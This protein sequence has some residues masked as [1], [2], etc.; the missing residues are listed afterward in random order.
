MASNALEK[1]LKALVEKHYLNTE[2]PLLFA[3]WYRLNERKDVYLLEVAQGV[4]DPGDGSWETFTFLSPPELR[5]PNGANLLITY[6]SPE[7]FFYAVEQ[8]DTKGHA[9]LCEIQAH[10][11]RVLFCDE[12]SETAQHIKK[13]I[14]N[15]TT[16]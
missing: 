1:R 9:L 13:V 10:G 8:E 16:C 5:R 4:L 11:C 7:E 14:E 12:Q 6:L 3:A 15:A 2:T